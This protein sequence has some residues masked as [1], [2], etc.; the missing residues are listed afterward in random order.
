MQDKSKLLAQYVRDSQ[1]EP[2][3][4]AY[5]DV[6]AENKALRQLLQEAV[7]GMGGAYAIWAPKAQAQLA[8][9]AKQVTTPSAS[10]KT[11]RQLREQLARAFADNER[12]REILS[13]AQ[14]YITTKQDGGVAAELVR[15]VL[16]EPP[17]PD[18]LNEMRADAQK[19]A[20]LN[21]LVEFG[22]YQLRYWDTDR[23]SWYAVSPEDAVSHSANTKND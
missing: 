2:P 17:S 7:A 18:L 10:E 13:Y 22:C 20:D 21:H 6:L 12:L 16:D 14:N 23:D 19:W 11:I 3:S 15:E 9:P 4:A 8:L 5:S 1:E